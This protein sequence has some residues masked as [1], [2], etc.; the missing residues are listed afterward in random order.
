MAN[1]RIDV[2]SNC[3][4]SSSTLTV[5]TIFNATY[6]WY[7]K[8][9]NNDS[10]FLGSGY[11]VYIPF[12]GAS[13]TGN[14]IS[15]VTVNTGCVK[16]AY[17][18]HLT[19]MCYKVL[20]V[21]ITTFGGK[22]INGPVVL[23]WKTLNETDL[24]CYVV[25][26][27]NSNNTYMETGR[28]ISKGNQSGESVYDFIDAKPQTGINFYRL[29]LLYNDH[30]FKYSNII[31]VSKSSRNQNIHCYPNPV[32]GLLTID[33]KNPLRHQYKITLLNLLNQ[34]LWETRFAPANNNTLQIIR[35]ASITKGIYLIRFIDMFTNEEYSEKLIFL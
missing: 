3:F 25:E 32:S 16:R 28:V 19:G 17:T 14:Y 18:Y 1:Y 26:R 9:V 10:T 31:S 21:T 13:D 7:K 35:P 8:G 15:Y 22:F 23:T 27:R 12:V 2:D 20:P 5:D 11:S 6:A 34:E 29:K 4:Q 33:F 24:A 30:S